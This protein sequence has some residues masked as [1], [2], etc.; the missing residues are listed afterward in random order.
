MHTN[1]LIVDFQ[2]VAISKECVIVNFDSDLDLTDAKLILLGSGRNPLVSISVTGYRMEVRLPTGDPM[3][4]EL[5]TPHGACVK[6][7]TGSGRDM[8]FSN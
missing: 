1:P 5:K 8:Y 3:F 7:V 6:Y 4:A 2:A